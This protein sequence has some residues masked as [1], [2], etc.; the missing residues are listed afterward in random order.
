MSVTRLSSATTSSER[1]AGARYK[2]R[3]SQTAAAAA[4]RAEE[5]RELNSPAAARATAA[6]DL[7]LTTQPADTLLCWALCSA[8][9]SA[10]LGTLLC[11]ALCSAGHSAL[12]GAL[13]CWHSSLLLGHSALQGSPVAT[14][15][16]P[17]RRS[18]GSQY[19]RSSSLDGGKSIAARGKREEST[20]CWR[21]ISGSRSTHKG[22]MDSLMIDGLMYD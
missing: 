3:R 2:A 9:H 16:V 5:R 17:G 15:R 12:L 13:L 11:W 21:G 1:C 10:L 7:L 22:L 4:Q 8:G 20:S 19:S 18:P 14:G 6:A